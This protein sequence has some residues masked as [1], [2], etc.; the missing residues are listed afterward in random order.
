MNKLGFT[1]D[2]PNSIIYILLLFFVIFIFKHKGPLSIFQ[3]QIQEPEYMMNS[4]F[5]T[6]CMSI[7]RG[8][9]PT[10]HDF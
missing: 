8:F 5:A 3:E 7:P 4:F 6:S 10:H 1:W 9:L 2:F